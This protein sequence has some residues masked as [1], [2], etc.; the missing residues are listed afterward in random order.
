MSDSEPRSSVPSWVIRLTTSERKNGLP[1]VSSTIRSS[2]T[3]VGS[4]LAVAR[5]YAAVSSRSG[6]AAAGAGTRLAVQ[7]GERL[8]ERVRPRPGRC[9]GRCRRPA[10]ASRPAR[11]RGAAAAAVT[12]CRPS[13]GRRGSPTRRVRGDAAQ[14]LG[15]G[16]EQPELR[17]VRSW[18]TGSS[19]RSGII[20]FNAGNNGTNAADV[21]AQPSALDS[22]ARAATSVEPSHA[23]PTWIHGQ[24]G[25]APADSWA[26]P[27]STC[28]PRIRA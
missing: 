27:H 13:A 15:V 16:L 5:M 21:S 24:Y 18:S 3:G 1:S 11:A 20:R 6:R 8:R 23:L 4:T 2:T 19:G 28:A 17:R 22:L 10:G 26:R 7:L 14:E 25:G 9:R 12:A